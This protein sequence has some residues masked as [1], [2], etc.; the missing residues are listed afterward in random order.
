M[1]LYAQANATRNMKRDDRRR[2][3]KKERGH[4]IRHLERFHWQKDKPTLGV[5]PRT[6]RLTLLRVGCSTNGALRAII[7][8]MLMKFKETRYRC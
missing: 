1:H 2:G 8:W 3:K 7:T 4:A 6:C 5:E